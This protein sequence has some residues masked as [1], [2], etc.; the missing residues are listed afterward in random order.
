MLSYSITPI[1]YTSD[2]A[3]ADSPRISSGAMYAGV[4]TIVPGIVPM[5]SCSQRA[6]PKS[7]SVGSAPEANPSRTF[8][9]FTSR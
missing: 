8:S 9:G 4:P 3:S 6:I 7:A 2:A 1:A 5:A